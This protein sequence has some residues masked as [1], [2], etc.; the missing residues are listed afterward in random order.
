MFDSPEAFPRGDAV[1]R[2][3]VAAQSG[4]VIVTFNPLPAGRYAFAFHHDENNNTEFDRT[5]LGLPDE[6]FGFSNDAPIGFGP[7]DFTEAAVA[8]D[9]T[10]LTVTARMRYF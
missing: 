10:S 2:T 8:F 9:G 7:P 3:R 4:S 1:A 6:G 5:L